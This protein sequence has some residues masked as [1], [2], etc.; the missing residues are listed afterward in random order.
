M[1]KLA[2]VIQMILQ[3]VCEVVAYLPIVIFLIIT[4]EV[5]SRYFFGSPTSWA[6]VITQHLFLVVCLFGGVY[7]FIKK[8]HIKIEMLHDSFPPVLKMFSKLL[9]LALFLVF[10]GVFVWKGWYMAQVSISGGEI[11]RGAFALPIYPFKALMP[12]VGLLFLIQ[13]II[14]IL[15][16]K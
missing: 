4:F 3:K 6:W 5:V 1:K 11:A 2:D 9:T 10:A 14:S 12:L 8:S 7:A 16:D 13:G 15:R